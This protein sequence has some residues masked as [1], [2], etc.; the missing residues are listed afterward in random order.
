MVHLKG[1]YFR[2]IVLFRVSKGKRS[3]RKD[4]V[5]LCKWIM[6]PYLRGGGH[7]DFDVDRIGVDIDVTV[8]SA[9]YLV[10]QWLDSCLSK[11]NYSSRKKPWIMSPYLRRCW[12]RHWCHCLVCTISC[13]PVVGLLLVRGKPL[14]QRFCFPLQMNPVPLPKGRGAYLFWCSS[15]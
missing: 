5:S 7:I 2:L 4:F 9:Q 3:S 14:Q 13:E 6:S 8:L 11:G 1:D 10:N 15:G 12:H